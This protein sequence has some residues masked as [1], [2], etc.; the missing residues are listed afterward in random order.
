[1]ETGDEN[2]DMAE[3]NAIESILRQ[4]KKL[5]ILKRRGGGMVLLICLS[6]GGYDGGKVKVARL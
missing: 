3:I 2:L 1:M 6:S 5:K 4:L